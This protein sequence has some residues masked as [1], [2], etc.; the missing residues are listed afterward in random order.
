M[1]DETDRIILNLLQEDS[2][3]TNSQLAQLAGLSASSCWRRIKSLEEIGLIK[4]YTATLDRTIAG[5]GFAAIIHV[6]L[7][8]QSE[9]TVTEFCRAIEER[10]EILDCYATTGDSDYHLRVV[11]RDIA[12]YN[13]F[14]D[15]FLF[16]LKGVAH[17]RSNIIL[18]DIKSGLQLPLSQ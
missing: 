18:K 8:R 10:P 2:R 1:I 5:F 6:G 17:V 4:G 12:D 11:A 13:D 14:L 16:K 3:I 15:N 7:S 9:N